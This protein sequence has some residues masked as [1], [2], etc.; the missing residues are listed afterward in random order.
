MNMGAVSS[1]VRVALAGVCLDLMT[2]KALAHLIMAVPGAVA[3]GNV[4]HYVGAEREVGR[5]LEN[6]LNRV[7]IVDFDQNA[8]E[9]IRITERLRAEYRDVYVFAASANAEPERIIAAMRAG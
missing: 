3:V 1:P 8:E 6:A 5:A 4:D 7:C 9:A 2:Y